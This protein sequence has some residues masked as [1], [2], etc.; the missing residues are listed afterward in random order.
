MTIGKWNTTS[1]PK[2]FRAMSTFKLEKEPSQEGES[3][4][5]TIDGHALTKTSNVPRAKSGF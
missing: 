2:T 4:T 3:W 5:C 1:S